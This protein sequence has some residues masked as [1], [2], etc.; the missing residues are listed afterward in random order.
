MAFLDPFL[1][2]LIR[3]LEVV[4]WIVI[5][6]VIISWLLFFASHS[7]FRW[8]NRGAYHVLEQLNDICTRFARPF[9]GPIQRL[10]RRFNTAGIDWSPLIVLLLVY[11]LEEML[12]V[13]RN[14][15]IPH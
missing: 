15:I 3:I 5:V 2:L 13:A 1:N 11:F 8:R 6:W 10:L 4:K 9:V 7:S 14:A 12:A